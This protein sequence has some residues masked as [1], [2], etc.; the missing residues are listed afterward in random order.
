V[1]KGENIPES[2]KSLTVR[3]IFSSMTGT[4]TDVEVGARMTA[5]LEKLLKTFNAKLRG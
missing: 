1:F 4:L 5:V 3:F 2:F